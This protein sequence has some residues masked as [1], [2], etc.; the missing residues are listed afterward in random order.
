MIWQATVDK[1]RGDG[2]RYAVP[3]VSYCRMSHATRS[4][5]SSTCTGR[6][7]TTG[8]SSRTTTSRSTRTARSM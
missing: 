8:S 6:R 2:A 7:G 3:A 5:L 1:N 4:K